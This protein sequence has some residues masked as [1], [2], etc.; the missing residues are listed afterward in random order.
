[1]L[2]SMSTV[3]GVKAQETDTEATFAEVIF[4]GLGI[5]ELKDYNPQKRITRGEFA[6]LISAI[7]LYGEDSGGD[8]WQDTMFGND[9]AD[10]SV[11]SVMPIFSDVDASHSEYKGISTVVGMG[12]M[13][14]IGQNTFAPNSLLTVSEVQKVVVSMLGYDEIALAMGGYPNGYYKVAHKCKLLTGV[15]Q[16]GSDTITLRNAVTMLY[17]AFDVETKFALSISDG[18][19]VY[20]DSGE[21]FL[22]CYLKLDNVEGTITDNGITTLYSAASKLGENCINVGNKVLNYGEGT[23]PA[24]KH[25]GREVVAYYSIDPN[26][27]DTLVY[28]LPIDNADVITEGTDFKNGVMYYTI[29]GKDDSVKVARNTPIIYNGIFTD[30]YTND[31]LSVTDGKVT[32]IDNDEE[33]LVIVIEDAKDMLVSNVSYPTSKVY[34]TLKFTKANDGISTLS[35]E[36]GEKYEKV[37]ILDEYG[38][39]TNIDSIVKGNV[40]RVI[41]S[42]DGKSYLEVQKCASSALEVELDSYTSEEFYPLNGE[43][44]EFSEAYQKSSNKPLLNPG[45]LYKV[46]VNN[47]NRIVWVSEG[48]VGTSKIGIFTGIS[49]VGT[50]GFD[51]EFAIRLYTQDAKI[52]ILNLPDRLTVNRERVDASDVEA[53]LASHMGKAVLFDAEDGVLTNIVT[54]AAYGEEGVKDWYHVSPSFKMF[55]GNEGVAPFEMDYQEPTTGGAFGWSIIAYNKSASNTRFTV[56]TSVDDFDNEKRFFVNRTLTPKAGLIV[57]AYSTIKNDPVPNVFIFYENADGGAETIK[58]GDQAL[59][60]TRKV[61]TVNADGDSVN[62]LKGYNISYNKLTEVT[63]PLSENAYMT[64]R[65][66]SEVKELVPV[67]PDDSEEECGPLSVSDLEP[68][69]IVRY[70]KN[71]DGEITI[72][73]IAFDYSQMKGFME[74][75]KSYAWSG[76]TSFAG[77]VLNVTDKGL[78]IVTNILP[79]EIDYTNVNHLK[80]IRSYAFSSSYPLVFV[81]NTERGLTFRSGT[82]EEITSYEATG[83][84]GVTD[85]ACML[86]HYTGGRMGGVIYVK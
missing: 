33:G 57:E 16:A 85:F 34:N 60:I 59:L 31:M 36:E 28:I 18:E 49:P 68:G 25:I 52:E 38:K 29:D 83:D 65:N 6:T 4:D 69:D 19:L 73:R 44:L 86:A 32:L 47:S 72:M 14:G 71:G 37:L 64:K 62:A 13:N 50:G 17:N 8:V 35:L 5:I 82:Y 12:Y 9:N 63:I 75:N 51:E 22:N 77:P 23:Y 3:I 74:Q 20:E 48:T 67:K 30:S 58:D 56:P 54:P 61:N 11:E 10:A 66:P 21:T 2:L 46:Y 53:L 15:D 43:M 40:I 39:E 78:K 27:N 79:E 24:S 55:E 84:S 81:E 42:K 76:W 1:M 45:E 26:K 7:L 70:G 41:E 80:N